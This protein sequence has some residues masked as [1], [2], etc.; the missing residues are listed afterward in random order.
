MCWD[1]NRKKRH[2]YTIQEENLIGVW[3]DVLL[4][5]KTESQMN[6]V[7]NSITS[8]GGVVVEWRDI[9]GRRS[10]L[11]N[12]YHS[13]IKNAND[14]GRQWKAL[15]HQL[16]TLYRINGISAHSLKRKGE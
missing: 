7:I 9:D 6:A 14:D 8:G 15:N 5:K 13:A 2:F 3:C 4:G 1:R 11:V 12:R 16:V 10:F